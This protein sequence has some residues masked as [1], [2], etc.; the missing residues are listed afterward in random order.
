MRHSELTVHLWLPRKSTNACAG[1]CAAGC[2]MLDHKAMLT[3]HHPK[4][5]EA[6][7]SFVAQLEMQA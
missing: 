4:Y 7:R 6:E 1:A 3:V 2:S 5:G